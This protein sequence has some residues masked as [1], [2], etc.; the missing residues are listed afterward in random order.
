MSRG[1]RPEVPEGSTLA[2]AFSFV[3]RPVEIVQTITE[4]PRR[5]AVVV[6]TVANVKEDVV[7]VT[8]T[9]R[10]QIQFAGTDTFRLAVPANVSDRLRVEGDGIKERRKSGQA[11]PGRHGRVDH[12]AAFRSD[13][14]LHVRRDATIRGFPF[15]IRERNLSFNRS[16][17]WTWTVNRVRLPSRRTGPYRSTPRRPAWRRSIPAS[18]PCR[19]AAT[20][21]YLTYRYFEHPAQLTL[22]VT[23]HELQDVVETVVRRA[24]IEAVVTEDG[25]ITMR[26]RYDLKS[27]ERQRL[28]IT[29]RNPR[30]LG[31]DR[32]RTDR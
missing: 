6:G 22:S 18:C 26:A 30:I 12:R 28:A 29:L 31:I 7:Q 17:L 5:T 23:K 15:P 21:P 25:P 13:W 9:F 2:A 14:R 1:F 24:Y 11:K 10:Y 8:T 32:G 19:S 16:K 20:Q 4:R 27:S 3:T